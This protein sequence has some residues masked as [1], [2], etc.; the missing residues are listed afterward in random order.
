MT[1]QVIAL[2]QWGCN[3]NDA[4]QREVFAKR[5]ALDIHLVVLRQRQAIA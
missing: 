4:W 1:R 5:S 2:N 3:L